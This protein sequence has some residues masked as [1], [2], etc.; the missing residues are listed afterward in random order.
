MR[1]KV[2]TIF[3]VLILTSSFA[4]SKNPKDSLRIFKN[5]IGINLIPIANSSYASF[6]FFYKRQLKP[7]WFGR[8]SF[9]L[10]NLDTDIGIK[11]TIPISNNK[12]GI[13]FVQGNPKQYLHYNLGIEKRYGKGRIKYFFGFDFGYAHYKYET[14][15]VYGERDGILNNEPYANTLNEL[16]YQ[17]ETDTIVAKYKIISNSFALNPFY[18]LQLNITRRFFFSA[19]LGFSIMRNRINNNYIIDN[20]LYKS[21]TEDYANFDFNFSTV[22]SNF[23]F[24]YRF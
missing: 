22:S 1:I 11:K 18:G 19:Q 10:L 2:I 6:N 24:C 3:F 17:R 13:E 14:K 20:R 5:E 21:G 12:I 16:N 9:V 8:L 15:L 7:N 23:A 4:L